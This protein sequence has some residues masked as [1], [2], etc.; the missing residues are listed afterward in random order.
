M[1][2]WKCVIT[3]TSL[4]S[5]SL[6]VRADSRKPDAAGDEPDK[7]SVKSSAAKITE[8]VKS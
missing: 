7:L 8:F 6:E 3:L 4:P 2:F 1:I 5:S